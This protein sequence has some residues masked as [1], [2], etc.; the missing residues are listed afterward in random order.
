MERFERREHASD[1]VVV[2]E[3]LR[4]LLASN[5]IQEYLPDEASGKASV[6]P[7]LVR[8]LPLPNSWIENHCCSRT[9][10]LLMCR[11]L[12]RAAGYEGGRPVALARAVVTWWSA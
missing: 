5:L 2:V 6:L 8:D 3:Y 7:Q 4:G 12:A 10:L 1:A 9:E 11:I